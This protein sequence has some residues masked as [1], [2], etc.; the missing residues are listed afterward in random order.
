[1][2]L[3][4]LLKSSGIEPPAWLRETTDPEVTS[5]SSRAQTVQPGAVFIAVRG[6]TA[7]GHAFVGQAFENGCTA[8]ICEK[9]IPG[10][11]RIILVDN[12]R[13]A[14]AAVASAF[15]GHPSREMTLIG[16]TGTNGKTT[17]TYLLESILTAAGYH[18]GVIG[19]I[20]IRY[21]GEIH[22]NPVTTP[23]AIDLQHTLARMKTAGITHVIMEV[24]SHGID[25]HRI[26]GCH[27]DVGIFTNLSQDH[28]DYHPDMAHYFACKKRFF[29]DHLA[30]TGRAAVINMADPKGPEIAKDIP[31]P[32]LGTGI[33]KDFQVR[34][35]RIVDR[36]DGL[37]AD[38][39]M[40]RVPIHMTSPL[41]GRF[42]LEN[43]LSAAGAAHALGIAHEKIR[44]GIRDCTVIPGRLEKVDNRLDRHIF[45]D[46]AHTPDALAAILETLATR[47]PSRIITVFGC[48][49]DRDRKKRPLMGQTAE[50][51][52]NIIIVTSD[53][54]RSE[55]PDRIISDILEGIS[56]PPYTGGTPGTSCAFIV[57]PDRR[58]ALETAVA[59]SAPADI[60]L[61]A[62]KGHE[63]YQ[64][65]NTGTI[66]FDDRE[67]LEKAVDSISPV[68]FTSQDLADALGIRPA[69]DR[70][71]TPVRFRKISTDSR[72]IHRDDCFV[73]L[74]GDHFDGSAF[75]PELIKKGIQG[76]V[77]H[78]GFL[79]GLDRKIR[80][81]ADAFEFVLFET[82]S[83]LKALGRLARFQRRR[84]GTRVV[85]I[86]GA[87]GK[88]TT[89]KLTESVFQQRPPVLATTGN[90]NNEIG[91]PLTLM[92]LSSA[93]GWA[94]VE[95]G[96]NHPGEISRLSGIAE[97][98]IAV[99][100]T[101]TPVHLEG[102]GTVENIARAKAEIFDHMSVGST[103][104]INGD[105][106]FAPL[107]SDLAARNR[108]IREVLTF[109]TGADAD[110]RAC[111]VSHP[112]PVLEF[113]LCWRNTRTPMAVNSPAPFM[114]TNA[115]AACAAALTAGL[116]P[117]LIAAGL[118]KFSPVRGRMDIRHLTDGLH[119]IDDTYNA[120][121]ASMAQALITLK[122][123]SR[124]AQG[125]AVLGDMLELGPQSAVL[126]EQAGRLAAESGIS[127]LFICGH[128]ALDV[129][130]GAVD[131]GFDSR[132][133]FIGTKQEITGHLAGLVGQDSGRND[134][135]DT[136][137][138]I[139]GSRGMAMEEIINELTPHIKDR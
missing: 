108:N 110:I 86:T 28:L 6:F 65:T 93:H 23:D 36:I 104:I 51:F 79:A 8:A 13:R 52:S 24:S 117:G 39:I 111:R 101:I 45:V 74:K 118:A 122:K 62:G 129:R 22:D 80:E 18:P 95:M 1:M 44:A 121:P 88:T 138:L 139:K 103:A 70:L 75:I 34:A 96:M 94:V 11:E 83:T 119:L 107:L 73:A 132:R 20:N 97:P 85:A 54:P 123:M 113:D 2:K 32:V 35:E 19:T 91:L 125:M 106:D 89:R 92:N 130:K 12:S 5:V 9:M 90:L 60:I 15:T 105:D 63:T 71:S 116:P 134:R 78:R 136:W 49:G 68:P 48:G 98:D 42:N 137:L 16:V 38:L 43:I 10:F 27:F 37:T 21:R 135:P 76:L 53:N 41:T 57:E 112:G 115:L 33:G 66:H 69:V 55:P 61:A 99:I 127:R 67:V 77:A 109:G 46:Y 124:G 40:D 58:K 7:D 17:V 4:D 26:D 64:I 82:E 128:H 25:L 59:L 114:L 47:A 120:S 50:T 126:H 133:I 87:N 30:R 102:L 131:A 100:T 72:D 81:Q 29:T 3:T 14:M 84:T 56:C 31:I